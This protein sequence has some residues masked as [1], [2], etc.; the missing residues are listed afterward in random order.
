MS[1]THEGDRRR[2]RVRGPDGE[3]A[4][5]D[6]DELWQVQQAQAESLRQARAR[7]RRSV[8]LA[9]A[10]M[11]ALALVLAVWRL[12]SPTAAPT[13]D[14][15]AALPPPPR[16]ENEAPVTEPVGGDRSEP[17]GAVPES[18]ASERVA[19]AVRDWASAWADRDLSA[20]LASYAS[21]FVPPEGLTRVDWESARRRRLLEPA[22]IRVE[23]EGLEVDI[24]G[25]GRAEARFRQT[26]SSP[27]YSDV[28]RKTLEL[29]EEEGAWR[30]VAE[31][32]EAP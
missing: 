6:H 4:W 31:R 24:G 8:L 21:G 9:L 32:S 30:I 14:P 10:A 23:V 15:A 19:D 27:L 28:V 7:R 3:D 26:Y 12:R 18:P 11:V 5:V 17:S 13:S 16:L 1:E 25:G 29:I 22:W 20:Y 2:Y